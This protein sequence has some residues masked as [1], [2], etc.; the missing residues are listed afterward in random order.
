LQNRLQ[1]F[2]YLCR[3]IKCTL[4]K[5]T[6]QKTI[7][8]FYEALAVTGLLCGSEVRTLTRQEL[9]QIEFSKMRFLRS[10]AGYRK[11]DKKRNTDVRQDVNMLNMG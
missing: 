9:K 10:V 8:E 5:K 11:I 3:K 7:L 6:Q 4:L 2:N 1:K